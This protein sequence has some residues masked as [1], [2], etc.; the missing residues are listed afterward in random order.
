MSIV[1]SQILYAYEGE[2][3]ED[4]VASL[5]FWV[6]DQGSGGG[7]GLQNGNGNGNGFQQVDRVG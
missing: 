3:G 2:T 6:G 7:G 5:D 1:V 4:V